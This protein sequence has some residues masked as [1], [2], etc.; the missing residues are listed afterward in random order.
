MTCCVSLWLF[1]HKQNIHKYARIKCT[2]VITNRSQTICFTAQKIFEVNNNRNVL[3][4][5]STQI[6]EQKMCASDFEN[7]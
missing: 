4:A 2:L 3:R 6:Y 7:D 1:N 5:K